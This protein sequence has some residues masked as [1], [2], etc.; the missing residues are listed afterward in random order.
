MK[1]VTMVEETVMKRHRRCLHSVRQSCF[2]TYE[3]V[4]KPTQVNIETNIHT[5]QYVFDC[6]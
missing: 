2:H 1:K 6:V 3:T 5:I 4:F